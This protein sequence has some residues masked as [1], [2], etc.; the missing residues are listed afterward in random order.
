MEM[1]E[2]KKETPLGLRDS[3]DRQGHPKPN[4]TPFHDL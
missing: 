3:W 2:G 1:W 4:L